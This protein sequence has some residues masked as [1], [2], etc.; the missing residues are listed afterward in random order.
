MMMMMMMIVSRYRVVLDDFP[1][2][3]PVFSLVADFCYNMAPSVTK[4]NV[5]QVRCAAHLLQMSGSGNLAD[6]ADK[7]LQACTHLFPSSQ[8]HSASSSSQTIQLPI[9]NKL[10][11][12]CRKFWSISEMIEPVFVKYFPVMVQ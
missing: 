8:S 1:G 10:L 3:Q 6:T 7:F 2:G 5:V 11:S 9:P 4:D 12:N